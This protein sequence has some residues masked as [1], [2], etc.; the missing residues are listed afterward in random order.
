[1]NIVAQICPLVKSR[2][3]GYA[4][5]HCAIFIHPPRAGRDRDAARGRILRTISIHPPRAGWDI[6]IGRERYRV[7]ISIH[8]PRA[9]R[10]HRALCGHGIR[11]I[12]IHPPRAGRDVK[13]IDFGGVA[14][15]SIHPPRAGRDG[16]SM[17]K[18]LSADDFNPPAPC[19]AG[20]RTRPF[21]RRLCRFQSTRPVRG[22][23]CIQDQPKCGG[24]ISIHPPRAGRDLWCISAAISATDFNPPAPCGAGHPIA[25]LVA[26]NVFISIHPPRAGRD[27]AEAYA[28]AMHPLFQSTRPV[29]GGTFTNAL[30]RALFIHFN[31]PAPCGAGPAGFTIMRFFPS[32]FQSTRPVRGG[33]AQF[34]ICVPFLPEF[35]STRPVRGGTIAALA[36]WSCRIHFNP[37]APCGAGPSLSPSSRY[38]H[39]DFN[40]PAPCGA[41]L[42]SCTKFIPC[43]FA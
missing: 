4:G 11:R 42:Q 9:G 13:P 34:R 37:P 35:Q 5:C 6:H 23:T 16:N 7:Q 27:D 39:H 18:R 24:R 10:D 2:R 43:I 14:L 29:R 20:H 38:S 3:P 15:I 28:E 17:D 41:G 26:G 19:G 1:M 22:G 30:A 25:V 31:P 40:P 33:T 36:K 21:D 32:L 8:P 12:S